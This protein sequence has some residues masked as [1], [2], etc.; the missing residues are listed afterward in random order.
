MKIQ[1]LAMN[2]LGEPDSVLSMFMSIDNTYEHK[3]CIQLQCTKYLKMEE[4]TEWTLLPR[5]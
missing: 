2:A 1:L 5:F 3:S 4:I